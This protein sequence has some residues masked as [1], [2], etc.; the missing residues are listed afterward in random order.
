MKSVV[1]SILAL[2]W[3]IVLGTAL[4]AGVS[5]GTTRAVAAEAAADEP[6][7]TP[8]V[9]T[10][11]AP[12]VP[13]K[14]TDQKWWAYYELFVTNTT[15]WPLSL[16]RLVVADAGDPSKVRLDMAGEE[17][18]HY[19]RLPGGD[20]EGAVL[21]P[22]QSCVIWMNVPFYYQAAIPE[23]LQ[24]TLSLTLDNPAGAK[25]VTT[26]PYT[27]ELP[28][29]VE[30]RNPIWLE[31]P[32]VRGN[33]WLVASSGG[34]GYH[35]TALMGIDCQ[36]HLAQRHAFD[37]MQLTPDYRLVTGPPYL[38]SS[39]LIYGQ[40]VMA[41]RNA[42]VARIHDGEPDNT[43][44][45]K[46]P[47]ITAAKAAGNYVVLDFGQGRY[48]LYAHLIPGSIR[49]VEGEVVQ[50]GEVLGLAGNSGNSDAPH[51]HFHVM[52]GPD[53]LKSNGLPCVFKKFT[54][55]AIAVM[56]LDDPEAMEEIENGA[57]VP[58]KGTPI[59]RNREKE[60]PQD[61]AIIDLR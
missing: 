19:L 29:A 2:L 55:T 36:W 42:V 28:A 27:V 54:L 16:D 25:K 1:R 58:V 43:P 40:E 34:L 22:S 24:H 7:L 3:P 56:P 14:M 50:R 35:R 15:A 44:G 51:L 9:I 20:V 32:P 52:D 49:V 10:V 41:V 45:E 31:V 30:D 5:A 33:R 38:N 37:L 47:G 59:R 13:V 46:P 4:S 17:I 8:V 26:T 11:L 18:A 61:M 53:P 12:T 60:L 48:G 23:A 21:G 6:Q 57:P 39:Y